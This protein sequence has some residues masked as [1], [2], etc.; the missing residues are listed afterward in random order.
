MMHVHPLDAP[1][2][3]RMFEGGKDRNFHIVRRMWNEC[4]RKWEIGS[5]VR[6]EKWYITPL[7]AQ[8]REKLQELPR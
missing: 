5:K 7:V 4:W 3:E 2:L 1:F 6:I 8:Y